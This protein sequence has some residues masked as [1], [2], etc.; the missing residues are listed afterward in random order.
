V[1]GALSSLS[2]ERAKNLA[3]RDNDSYLALYNYYYGI[4]AVL[5]RIETTVVSFERR[6]TGA[7]G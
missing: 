5:V 6:D 1:V 7:N 2:G 4:C 3:R